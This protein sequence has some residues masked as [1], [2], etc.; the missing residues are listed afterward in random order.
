MTAPQSKSTKELLAAAKL[1]ERTVFICLR[2]DLVADI[3]A[4]EHDLA[5]NVKNR[6]T[7]GR[8][9]GTA[10]IN[11]DVALIA[12]KR[13]EMVEATVPFRLR[14]MSPA[15]WR[16]FTSRHQGP[17]GGVDLLPLMTEAIP[18]SVVSPD[19]LDAEDWA[20]MLGGSVLVDGE[21]VEIEPVL[22]SAEVGKLIDAVWEMNMQGVNIPKS[23]PASAA[24]RRSAAE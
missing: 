5:E 7:N 13:A 2:G 24:K 3:E 22:A 20:K 21:T 12:E 1:P 19:D 23:L 4:L 18:A 17:N 9:G 14:G 15:R 16:S 6:A 10:K 8:L 11:G